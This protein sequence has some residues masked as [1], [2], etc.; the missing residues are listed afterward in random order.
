MMAI[1]TAITILI[2]NLSIILIFVK[3]KI[4]GQYKIGKQY[5]YKGKKGR[6]NGE[7]TSIFDV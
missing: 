6:N 4:F 7:R 5:I 3:V 1:K 2:I